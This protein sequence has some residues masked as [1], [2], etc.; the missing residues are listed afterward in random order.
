MSEFNDLLRAL[1]RV[2]AC[3][4][5]FAALRVASTVLAGSGWDGFIVVRAGAG[6]EERQAGPERADG[7]IGVGTR[8]GRVVTDLPPALA[9]LMAAD[10][11]LLDTFSAEFGGAGHVARVMRLDGVGARGGAWRA[12]GLRAALVVPEPTSAFM[13]DGWAAIFTGLDGDDLAALLD[14]SGSLCCALFGDILARFGGVS[15]GVPQ[16]MIAQLPPRQRAVLTHLAHGHSNKEIAIELGISEPAVSGHIKRL[17]ARFGVAT[18]RE[19]SA[20]V[21]SDGALVR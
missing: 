18:T 21:A 4:S 20:L 17:K 11:T 1:A 5:E 7:L 19:L 16:A 2:S 15:V 10:A 3:Q 6:G 13:I 9:Q 14:T 12:H 8:A